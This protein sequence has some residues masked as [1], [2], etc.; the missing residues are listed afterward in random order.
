PYFTTDTAAVLRAAEISAQII[1]KATRVDGVYDSDPEKNKDA[2]RFDKISYMDLIQK[3]LGVMDITAVSLCMDNNLPICVFD[4]TVEGNIL[5]AVTGS[6]I[7][8]IVS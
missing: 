4:S 3:K 5:K 1:F 6:D 2:R 8:T 7:G